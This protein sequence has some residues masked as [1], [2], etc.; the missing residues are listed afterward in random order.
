MG[1]VIYAGG[2][3]DS[4]EIVSGTPVESATYNA[5]YARAT[6]YCGTPAE[7]I[8]LGFYDDGGAAMTVDD[9]QTLFVHYNRQMNTAIASPGLPLCTIR[10]SSGD[11]W[12][13]LRNAAVGALGI[14][15]NTGTGGSPTWTQI[16][17]NI[18]FVADNYTDD[19]RVAIDSTGSHE[20]EWITNNTTVALGS[21]TNAGF[22]DAASADLAGMNLGLGIS[23]SEELCTEGLST[24]GAHVYTS[25]LSG[26]GTTS[27]WSGAYTDANE[28]P[29]SDS[30]SLSTALANQTSTFACGD[31]TTPVN[32]FLPCVF[33][34]TR[35]KNSGAPPENIHTVFRISGVDYASAALA[36]TGV[37]YTNQPTRYDEAP[38]GNAWTDAIFNAAERGV[39]S[40][41]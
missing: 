30:T 14:F 34:W 10:D 28:T 1:Q 29:M 8:R 3:L 38:D 24:V 6:I 21:F 13:Q 32:Y 12:V 41:T 23:Y 40:T 2:E 7:V 9:G 36:N 4:V 22:T 39:K 15:G 17:S 25:I 26:A 5:P 27:D 18:A 11:P 19:I 16:G 37:S 35:G 20:V 31:I 33:V